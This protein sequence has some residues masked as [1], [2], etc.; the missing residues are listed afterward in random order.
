MDRHALGQRFSLGGGFA[1]GFKL[2]DHPRAT[3]PILAGDSEFHA[4][5]ASKSRAVSARIFR[6]GTALLIYRSNPFSSLLGLS[7]SST[8]LL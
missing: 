1:L 8:T 2:Q 3:V 5:L 4:A 7:S 6:P